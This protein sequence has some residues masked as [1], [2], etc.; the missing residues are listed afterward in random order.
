MLNVEACPDRTRAP[1]AT[2]CRTRPPPKRAHFCL[3]GRQGGILRAPRQPCEPYALVLRYVPPHEAKQ[4]EHVGHEVQARER[5][6]FGCGRNDR[7]DGA[8]E[9]RDHSRGA[10][11][12]A[13]VPCRHLVS[14][15]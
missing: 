11:K 12:A 13:E 2:R 7:S 10:A 8:K 1:C 3:T 6:G 15:G 5:S 14:S 4:N 9:R